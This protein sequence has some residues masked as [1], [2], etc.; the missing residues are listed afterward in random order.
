M[1]PL[2]HTIS[3]GYGF[4]LL[5]IIMLQSDLPISRACIKHER[6]SLLDFK[7]GLN[8]S[9][10]RLSSWRGF[11]CCQWEGV[12][13]DYNT[14]HVIRLDLSADPDVNDN[15]LRRS[16]FR[17]SLF[18]LQHLEHLDLSRNSF[19]GSSIPP[20]LSKLQRLSFLSLSNAGF[21]G[22]VPLELGNMSSLRH[23]DISDNFCL[24]QISDSD[25]YWEYCLRSSKFDV[26][27]R[28]LRSL[29]FLG[30]DKVNL[31][32]ASK[33]WGEALS[34][35]ANLTQIHLSRCGLSGNIPD[36]SNLTS[37]SHLHIGSNSFPFQLPYWF[38]NMSSL[39]SLDLYDCGLNSTIP[40]N[41][42]PR[43]KL[44]NLVL[45]FNIDM[46]GSNLSFILDHSSSLVVLSVHHCNLGG[47]IPPSIADFSKLETMDLSKNNLNGSIPSSFDSLS[48]L[49][50][51][52][53]SDNQLTGQIPTSLCQLP[54]LSK[55][56]LYHNQ[57]SRTIPESVSKLASLEVLSL[58][59]NHLTGQIPSSLCE[60]LVLNELHLGHNQLS[61]TISNSISKLASLEV[62]TLPSN[63]LRG[64]IS[65]QMFDNL[66]RLQGLDLSENQFTI[67]I[68]TSWVPQFGHLEYLA[69]RSCNI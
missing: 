22:E 64:T 43:S 21:C 52:D 5:W 4:L 30:M 58:N 45:D 24:F 40:S 65:L 19:N 47:V 2:S 14:S 66:T 39:V 36:L 60:L 42:L 44:R 16:E 1:F 28:N 62:L 51:L 68:S 26:W 34:G 23:L 53:L 18:H 69:L 54:V 27:I 11:N 46:Q 56:D 49:A 59:Y 50:T 25:W 38:E 57:L 63:R 33:K 9:F 61:G 41:F 13:C 10:G 12:G 3:V 55:L 31:T 8:L 37:L 35:H 29:E 7:A 20:Q 17:P 6:I 48:S 67:A 32:M 15:W